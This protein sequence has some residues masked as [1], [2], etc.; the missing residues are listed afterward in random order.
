MTQLT[1]RAALK[2]RAAALISTAGDGGT[3]GQ[4]LIDLATDEAD[5]FALKSESDA[6][7]AAQAL[8]T[9]AL[10]GLTLWTGTQAEYDA[11][12]TKSATTLYFVTA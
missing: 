8:N 4:D 2:A 11:I 6:N 5:T 12:P 3:S 7:A 1:D 10:A 9:A